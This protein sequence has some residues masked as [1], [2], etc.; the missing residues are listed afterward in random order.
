[1]RQS[2]ENICSAWVKEQ[3]VDLKKGQIADYRVTLKITF[4]LKE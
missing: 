1:M 4:T 2:V 3:H